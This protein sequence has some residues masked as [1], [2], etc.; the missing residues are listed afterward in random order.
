[1][2]AAEARVEVPGLAGRRASPSGRT[3]AA[4]RPSSRASRTSTGSSATGRAPAP[5]R[6]GA[7]APAG[8]AASSSGS[9]RTRRAPAMQ[10]EVEDERLAAARRPSRRADG[11][12]DGSA[13][14]LR[15]DAQGASAASR[16]VVDLLFVRRAPARR[17]RAHAAPLRDRAGVRAR[18]MQGTLRIASGGVMFVFK[19][20][21]VGAGTMGGEIAQTIA[22]AGIP[23]VLKDVQPGVRGRTAWRRP[24]VTQGQLGALVE[25]GS[26]PRSRPPRRSRRSLGRITRHD[27]LRRLR[28]RRLRHRGRPRAHGDQAGGLRRARRARRRGTRSSPRTPRRC[29]SPRWP[30]PR[31]ARTRSSASTSS[32]R[33]R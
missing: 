17:A 20:A 24:Q 9:S 3:P 33:R 2:R 30:R 26:S 10:L 12:T 19:A 15:L 1:M 32:T 8:G 14:E 7:R 13:L 6:Y 18:P 31:S 11:A 27:E 5:G 22:A 4:G 25:K 29:R 21:V 16:V 28:R 23:V